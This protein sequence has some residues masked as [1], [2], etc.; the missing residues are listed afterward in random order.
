MNSLFCEIRDLILGESF[1][2]IS[3]RESD[4]T[5]LFA[6]DS[7]NVDSRNNMV[8]DHFLTAY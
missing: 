8:D 6:L 1:F 7:C 3:A 4:M 2:F 5:E